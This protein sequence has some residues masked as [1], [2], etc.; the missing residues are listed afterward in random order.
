MYGIADKVCKSY[1]RRRARRIRE[2][3]LA[4]EIGVSTA[5]VYHAAPEDPD[6]SGSVLVS[7]FRRAYEQFSPEDRAVIDHMIRHAGGLGGHADL[8]AALKITEEAAKQRVYRMKM[9]LRQAIEAEMHAKRDLAAN[10]E[11]KQ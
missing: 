5:S 3:P 6:V 7:A 9:R 4:D 8:A 11:R 10:K 2:V 1:V